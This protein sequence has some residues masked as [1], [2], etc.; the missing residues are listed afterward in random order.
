[1]RRQSERLWEQRKE[2][3]KD[4]GG[5]EDGAGEKREVER[6][7]RGWEV[8]EKLDRLQRKAGD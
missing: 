6:E 4:G 5:R 7:R 8:E 1:M 3:R 2:K